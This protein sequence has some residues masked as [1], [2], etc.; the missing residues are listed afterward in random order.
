LE[1]D[2]RDKMVTR[3]LAKDEYGFTPLHYAC[4]SPQVRV[5]TIKHLLNSKADP[6][7]LSEAN[8]GTVTPLIISAMV[9]NADNIRELLP[10]FEREEIFTAESQNDR[11]PLHFAAKFGHSIALLAM[12]DHRP[13]KLSP[14]PI[15]KAGCTPL[16]VACRHGK[17]L[18]AKV[19]I[20]HGA[21]I[22][23][24]LLLQKATVNLVVDETNDPVD[25]DERKHFFLLGTTP[26]HTAVLGGHLEVVKLLITGGKRCKPPREGLDLLHRAVCVGNAEVIKVLAM[27]CDN[28]KLNVNAGRSKCRYGDTA[29]HLAVVR[30]NLECVNALL[31]PGSHVK[32]STRNK[33][34]WNALHFAVQ[35]GAARLDALCAILEFKPRDDRGQP[36][37]EAV[38]NARLGAPDKSETTPL[39]LAA[40]LGPE[41][42]PG[43]A[44]VRALL[45]S[46]ADPLLRDGN[47]YSVSIASALFP[48]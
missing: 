18:A 15:D 13:G 38:A 37:N 25:W 47:G 4:M 2:T 10:N 31:C 12:L 14:D 43:A 41:K 30:G 6:C 44:V 26:L 46:G 1:E 33:A 23:H 24:D 32:P 19:L 34:G 7:Q 42:D 35:F 28:I 9:G 29:L 21:D 11:S 20:E 8:V 48:A 17:E 3:S 22:N 45:R 39:I 5:K 36:A 40:A 16:W 27:D